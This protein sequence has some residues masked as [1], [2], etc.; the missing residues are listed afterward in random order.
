MKAEKTAI[1]RYQCHN[2]SD[3]LA[4]HCLSLETTTIYNIQIHKSA[5]VCTE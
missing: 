3:Q 1:A 2:T 4:G 5:Q